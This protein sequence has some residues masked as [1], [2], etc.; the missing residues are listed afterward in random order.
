MCEE[1]RGGCNCSGEACE[2]FSVC[3]TA[4]LPILFS[5]L[6]V[7]AI[8]FRQ[9]VKYFCKFMT[10]KIEEA[11]KS[12]IK[13]LPPPTDYPAPAVRTV[14]S[15]HAKFMPSICVVACFYLIIKK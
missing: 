5:A 3:K 13:D 14:L 9:T 12:Q 4:F 8:F 11:R 10:K 7:T 1:G 2:V 6:F 15:F